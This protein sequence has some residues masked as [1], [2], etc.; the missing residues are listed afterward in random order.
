MSATAGRF[1]WEQALRQAHGIPWAQ[2]AVLLT[3][4]TYASS[5][6]GRDIRPSLSRLADM[7]GTNRSTWTRAVSA[8]VDAGWLR[9]VED[10]SGYGRPS[11]Y[12]LAIPPGALP[13]PIE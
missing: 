6:T 7:T 11:V 13:P 2:R 9:L 10:R 5:A 12:A 1:E 8:G 3:L 4:A